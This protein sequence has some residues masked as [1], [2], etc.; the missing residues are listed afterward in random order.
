EILRAAIEL[1]ADAPDA[2]P[3][4]LDDLVADILRYSLL[5]RDRDRVVVHRLVQEVLRDAMNEEDRCPWE[6]RA[7]EVVNRAFPG[8]E[9]SN[10]GV[11][12]RLL[13]HP[14][15]G[16]AYIRQ[17]GRESH[18]AGRLLHQAGHSLKERARYV[19]A[20]PLLRRALAIFERALGPDHPGT[21]ASLNN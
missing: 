4:H 10:W 19:E 18:E 8:V 3:L 15:Q 14:P 2:K 20:E 11:C 13:P 6:E 21:A 12:D 17:R 16:A 5:R 1:Q 7:V 9:F